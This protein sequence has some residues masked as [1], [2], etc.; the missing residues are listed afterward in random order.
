[1]MY[2]SSCIK[3]GNTWESEAREVQTLASNYYNSA[4]ELD[5]IISTG[6]SNILATLLTHERGI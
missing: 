3:M 5:C 1:M 4:V 2:G 6:V